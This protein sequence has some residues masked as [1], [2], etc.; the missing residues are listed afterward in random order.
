MLRPMTDANQSTLARIH[1]LSFGADA[2]K[3]PE[4]YALA[5]PENVYVFD[6]PI[7]AGLIDIPMGLWVGGKRLDLRGVAG[8]GV[9]PEHRG[10]GIGRRMM[11]AYLEQT[12]QVAP[13]SALYAS[14]RA[15]YRKVGYAIGGHRNLGT[16]ATE[17]FAAVGDRDD[18]WRGLEP[19]DQDALIALRH[20]FGAL[21]A[22]DVDRGPYLWKRVWATRGK[23]NL[24]F[25]H[26]GPDGIDGWVVLKQHHADEG[27]LKVE[28]VDWFATTPAALRH[29]AGFLG[30]F[31]SM[32]RTIEVPCCPADPLIDL[33][34]EHNHLVIRVFEPWM[35]RICDV[36]RALEERGWPSGLDVT[37]ELEVHDSV[38]RDNNG[39]FRVRIRNGQARVQAGSDGRIVMDVRA[40]GSLYTGHGDPWGLRLRGELTA[41]DEDLAGLAAAFSA[42]QPVLTDFF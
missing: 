12:A 35:I 9:A 21:R 14:A 2:S 33:L 16:G 39:R 10:R 26:E 32:A 7:T 24:G 28:V 1:A 36:R 27:W 6:D 40:L 8:V 19:A 23:P 25:V 30:R 20:R 34:P 11:A 17:R 18:R 41:R 4:W 5:E 3:I 29:V 22:V 31:N 37:L 15:L 13:L 38:L 42:P